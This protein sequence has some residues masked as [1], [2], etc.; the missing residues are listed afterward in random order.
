[1]DHKRRALIGII[2]FAG[3]CLAGC[4]NDPLSRSENLTQWPDITR[5]I[6]PDADF[7]PVL[8]TEPVE[9]IP[10]HKGAASAEII[11][12][13][14][15]FRSP[16]LLGGQAAQQGLS[17]N[18]CHTNGD[19]NRHFFISGISNLAGEADV[20]NFHFSK[21]LGD[22]AFNPKPIPSLV[23]LPRPEDP[24]SRRMREDVILRLIESEFDGSP[25]TRSLTNSLISYVNSLD[26][27]ACQTRT[28]SG[29]DMLAFRLEVIDET[30]TYWAQTAAAG[31]PD[32][33]FLTDALRQELGR[34]HQRFPYNADIRNALETLSL[35]L[36]DSNNIESAHSAHNQWNN[37]RP[38][39]ESH[40]EN[41]LFSPEK[42]RSIPR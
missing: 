19:I 31:D 25:P 33:S 6:A 22:E 30:M 36:R 42:I 35:D 8:T 23:N 15:A 3:F 4:S 7:L 38:I 9:C 1:M 12:G 32:R 10:S 26:S 2:I 24:V 40:F 11:L 37:L 5:W 29:V 34:L 21:T 18:S 20:T 17:C 13:R 41:S 16:F 27:S 39:A 14:M 28:Q